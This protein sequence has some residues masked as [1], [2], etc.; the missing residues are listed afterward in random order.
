MHGAIICSDLE[1]LNIA[2]FSDAVTIVTELSG[3]YSYMY[4]NVHRVDTHVER[5]TAESKIIM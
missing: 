5:D 4:N 1:N 2:F 3:W